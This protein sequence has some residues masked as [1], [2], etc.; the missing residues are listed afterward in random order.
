MIIVTGAAGFI[1]SRV[2]HLLNARG[3]NNILAIDRVE[4]FSKTDYL[5]NCKCVKLPVGDKRYFDYPISAVIHIGAI[6]NTLEK[7][8][9]QFN[10]YNIL[11][12]LFWKDFAKSRKIPFVWASS[13]AIYGNG[14]GP[15]NQYATS[16][17][18]SEQQCIGEVAALR[19]FNVYGP[20]ESHKGRMASV[21]YNWFHQLKDTGNIRVFEQSSLYNR[22]LI[23]VDDICRVVLHMVENYEP[24]IY[25]VGTGTAENMEKIAVMLLS[26]MNLDHN[27]MIKVP[28]PVDL[29]SQYQYNTRAILDNLANVKFDVSSIR[30]LSTGMVNYIDYL[31]SL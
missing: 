26:N 30:P 24:G 14:E 27:N 7:E 1:G 25:D 18:L 12:T 15:L 6:S 5:N 17:L 3:I 4:Q 29:I 28:M 16:K 22:D 23:H 31:N 11:N 19:F 21:I 2:V 8:W 20:N 10:T 9:E 13:S